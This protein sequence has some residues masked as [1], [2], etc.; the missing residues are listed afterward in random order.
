M[1]IKKIT[2][3]KPRTVFAVTTSTG[4]FI[5][6]GLAHHNCYRCNMML[7]GNQGEFRDRIRK[8][9]GDKKVDALLKAAKQA[10]PNFTAQDYL[11]LKAYY[12]HKLQ[13]LQ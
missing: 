1:K 11:E 9:L 5:A 7:G 3:V 2:K 4:T 8:E 12:K 13:E 10:K 6:D